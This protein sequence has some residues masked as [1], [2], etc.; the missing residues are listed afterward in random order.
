MCCGLDFSLFCFAHIYTLSSCACIMCDG[1][2]IDIPSSAYESIPLSIQSTNPL[3]NVGKNELTAALRTPAE[4]PWVADWLF[5]NN[6]TPFHKT[7]SLLPPEAFDNAL[8]MHMRHDITTL[9]PCQPSPTPQPSQ[10]P[11]TDIHSF[12]NPPSRHHYQHSSS[13]PLPPPPLTQYASGNGNSDSNRSEGHTASSRSVAEMSAG[14]SLFPLPPLA[15][16]TPLKSSAPRRVLVSKDIDLLLVPVARVDHVTIGYAFLH[17]LDDAI[18]TRTPDKAPSF[19]PSSSNATASPMLLPG[20]FCFHHSRSDFCLT[21]LGRN[22]FMGVISMRYRTPTSRERGFF[23]VPRANYGAGRLPTRVLSMQSHVDYRVPIPE[24]EFDFDS[25]RPMSFTAPD[26]PYS[27]PVHKTFVNAT[28][29]AAATTTTTAFT[30]TTTTNPYGVNTAAASFTPSVPTN[31]YVGADL[32]PTTSADPGS[33]SPRIRNANNKRS[34]SLSPLLLSPNMSIDFDPSWVN[35]DDSSNAPLSAL[36]NVGPVLTPS[37]SDSLLPDVV[38]EYLINYIDT[39]V[40]DHVLSDVANGDATPPR[41]PQSIPP[42]RLDALLSRAPISPPSSPPGLRTIP[43]SAAVSP[44]ATVVRSRNRSISPDT[45][46]SEFMVI[47]EDEYDDDEPWKMKLNPDSWAED[48]SDEE[49]RRGRKEKEFDHDHVKE[50]VRKDGNSG[51]VNAWLTN[52]DRITPDGVGVPRIAGANDTSSGAFD[53]RGLVD[54]LNVIESSFRGTFHGPKVHKDVMHPQTGELMSR[55]TGE[56]YAKFHRVD[57]HTW[58]AMKIWAAQSYYANLL[59]V[60]TD[61][62]F[63]PTGFSSSVPMPFAILPAP[64]MPVDPPASS[65]RVQPANSKPQSATLPSQPVSSLSQPF[66]TSIPSKNLSVPVS[67]AGPPTLTPALTSS[68]PSPNLSSTTPLTSSTTAPTATLLPTSERLAAGAIKVTPPTQQAASTTS[69]TQT[70]QQAI[71]TQSP[72]SISIPKT[73]ATSQATLTPVST[74]SPSAVP[75]STAASFSTALPISSVTHVSTPQVST[76]VQGPFA[77]PIVPLI[78]LQPNRNSLDSVNDVKPIR[79]PPSSA[80]ARR[81]PVPLRRL[82]AAPL[83]PRPVPI[84]LAPQGVLAPP[85]APGNATLPPGSDTDVTAAAATAATVAAAA[86]VAATTGSTSVSVAGRPPVS[87]EAIRASKLEAKR[88]KNRLSAAKSNQKRREQLEAQKKELALL[89]KRIEELKS[90]KQLITQ[91]NE[92]L[93]KRMAQD[94]APLKS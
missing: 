86:A 52:G 90:R 75:V 94:R 47:D 31:G 18:F 16:A 19:V 77:S 48:E 5:D 60:S 83:A 71:S 61:V 32:N 58:Q 79:V 73:S 84:T 7:P 55:C 54:A 24:S 43:N 34:R 69:A 91:E 67:T 10:A 23:V 87:E 36:Q 35:L 30:A 81:A 59:P 50:K 49:N 82:V 29:T 9:A 8:A 21:A 88:I 12:R 85:G 15:S 63:L 72:A 76:P 6:A 20:R 4:L 93:K 37:T 26:Q 57:A 3:F 64:T 53:F 22:A 51:D 33:G 27:P 17:G 39:D 28:A 38:H 40:Y 42:E 74:S 11:F 46:S 70:T 65:S 1:G 68:K 62:Q 78:P 56:V 66:S 13:S 44:S 14:A 80:R 89:R 92:L 45:P 41:L 2:K 25:S